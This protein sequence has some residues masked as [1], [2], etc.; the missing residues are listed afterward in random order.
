[1]CWHS[2]ARQAGRV[3]GVVLQVGRG[4]PP[5][6]ILFPRSPPPKGEALPRG[7][8]GGATDGAIRAANDPNFEP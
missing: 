4:R 6:R 8:G 1:M 3:S 2:T 5:M 7:G